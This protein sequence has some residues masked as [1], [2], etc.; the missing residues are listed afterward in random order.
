ME[1]VAFGKIGSDETVAIILTVL[2]TERD[3]DAIQQTDDPS[4]RPDPGE[5]AG[6]TPAHGF[7]PRE[8]S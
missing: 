3:H 5:G 1:A 7:R 6:S 8:T 2:Q 4:Q